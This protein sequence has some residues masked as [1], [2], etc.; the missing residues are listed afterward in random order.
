MNK[1]VMAGAVLATA[2]GLMFM[3]HPAL[4][5]TPAGSSQQAK[6][7]CVGGNDC[8]GKSACKT[9][10]SPGPGQNSCKGQGVVMT[11]TTTECTDK[12]GKPVKM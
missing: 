9:A 3:A 2:V 12:G 1:G 5:Q 8:K 6:V 7:K 11:K 4:A 10:T